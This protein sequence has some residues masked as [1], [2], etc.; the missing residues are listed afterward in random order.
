VNYLYVVGFTWFEM[1]Y[2]AA[3]AY[4]LFA[5]LLVITL[6]QFRMVS[7]EPVAAGSS[8]RACSCGRGSTC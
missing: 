2:A 8:R 3:I 6:I 5:L 4:A 1:G 7:R